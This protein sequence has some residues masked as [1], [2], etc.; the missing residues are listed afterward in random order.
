MAR[1]VEAHQASR[2]GLDL[3]PRKNEPILSR[4]VWNAF[5]FM[6][7]QEAGGTLDLALLLVAAL[8]LDFAEVVHSLLELAGEPLVVQAE[9]GEGAVGVDDVEVGAVEEG[10][11]ERGYPI[12]A[13]GGVGEFLGELGLG[14]SRGVV[15]VEEAAT[16]RVVRGSVFGGEN[17]GGGR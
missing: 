1:L 13:P 8:G 10:G 16:L 14:G 2:V 3:V 12:D 17:G 9:G 4:V 6:E 7:F 5:A 15:F 11:F